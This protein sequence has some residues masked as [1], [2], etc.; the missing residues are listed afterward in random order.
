[1][2]KFAII[3]L[4]ALIAPLYGT[5][6]KTHKV[7]KYD[8]I[9]SVAKR[10]KIT[11]K[12]LVQ[13]NDL[14]P[15]YVLKAGQMLV[16]QKGSGLV[17]A[18]PVP[19]APVPVAKPEVQVAVAKAPEKPQETQPAKQEIVQAP[20]TP[21]HDRVVKAPA[22][23]PVAKVIPAVATQT[24]AP[25][26]TVAKTLVSTPNFSWPTKGPV[27]ATFGDRKGKLRNEGI[28]IKAARGAAVNPCAPGRVLMVG[29]GPKA[30]GNIVMIDHGN[31]F[32]SAY[33]HL[34][35]ISVKKG[36]RLK[37]AQTIGSVG[38]TGTVTTSQLHFEL[39]QNGKSV[40]PL[41]YLK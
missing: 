36:Q 32:M 16:V 11:V 14:K 3:F 6:P 17:K 30:F 1:M 25:S 31:G 15:P 39:R 40:D 28:N 19:S 27:I 24:K 5:A 29:K 20:E 10:H 35:Q 41:K 9:L 12:E 4:V 37:T 26:K 34:D 23:P 8:T 7:G 18:N 21:D 13:Q 33:C 22:S 38:K 2:N